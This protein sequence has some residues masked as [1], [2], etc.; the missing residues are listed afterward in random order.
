M[1]PHLKFVCRFTIG[2]YGYTH[3][4]YISNVDSKF[5]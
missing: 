1:Y 4:H 2:S 5:L 3:A